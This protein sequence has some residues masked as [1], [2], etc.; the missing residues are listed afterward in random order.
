MIELMIECWSYPDGR[1]DFLW[2]VWREG[3]RLQMGGKHASVEA[4]EAEGL[5]F[6]RKALGRPPDRVTRL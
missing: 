3:H 2:S 5:A 1:S 4:A 6:C